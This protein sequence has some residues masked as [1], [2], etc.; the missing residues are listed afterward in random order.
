MKFSIKKDILLNSL[1][2]VSKALSSKNLIPVLSGIKFNLTNNGLFLSASDN[3]ISIESFIDKKDLEEL[4]ESMPSTYNFKKS[5][6]V[7]SFCDIAIHNKEGNTIGFIAIHWFDKEN[8]KVDKDTINQL[9]W[10]VEEHLIN[11][12]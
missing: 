2:K 8:M 5:I 12:K 1:N 4:K 10:Y 6:D 3:D 9:V 11:S 7:D